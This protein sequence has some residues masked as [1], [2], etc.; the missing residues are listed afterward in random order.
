[1]EYYGSDR[2]FSINKN[3]PPLIY[4][5]YM[6]WKCFISFVPLCGFLWINGFLSVCVNVILQGGK[7][8]GDFSLVRKIFQKDSSLTKSST[9]FLSL[10]C[11]LSWV[12]SSKCKYSLMWWLWTWPLEYLWI[13]IFLHFL[14]VLQ[15]YLHLQIP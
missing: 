4:E 11:Y 2:V 12:I 13:G 10:Y 3:A 14:K 9:Y 1:M 7:K 8:K 6:I 5:Y 15:Q